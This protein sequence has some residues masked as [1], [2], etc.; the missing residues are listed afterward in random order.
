MTN[1]IFK[2][3]GLIKNVDNKLAMI[4]SE[5]RH[6]RSDN[7]QI[8]FLLNK[9]LINKNLQKQVDEYFE[10]DETSPQTDTKEQDK[11]RDYDAGL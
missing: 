1:F 5:L 3:Q 2:S 9:L 10:D 4:L 7:I 11:S 8:L 6:Q